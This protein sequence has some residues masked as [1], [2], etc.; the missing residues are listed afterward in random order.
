[1][2]LDSIITRIT[3]ENDAERAGIIKDAQARAKEIIHQ[4]QQEAAAIHKSG[5]ARE[6]A[7]MESHRQKAVVSAQLEARKEILKAKQEMVDEVIARL[8]SQLKKDKFKKQQVSFE[9]IKEAP[10][11]IDFYLSRIRLDYESEIAKILFE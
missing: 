5:I 8:K 7:V 2:S 9:K 1:M 3:K 4:A 10:E 11:D 6:K